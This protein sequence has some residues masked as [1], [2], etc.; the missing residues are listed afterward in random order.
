MSVALGF[1]ESD[2][3]ANQVAVPHALDDTRP[4]QPDAGG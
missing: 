2:V 1:A 3:V 4:G